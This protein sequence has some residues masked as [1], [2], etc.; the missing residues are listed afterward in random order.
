V[1]RPATSCPACGAEGRPATGFIAFCGRCGHRW[2]PTSEEEQEALETGT[3]TRDYSGYRPDPKFID[4]ATRVTRSEFATRVPPPGRILDVGCGAGDF[5]G[6]AKQF[7]YSAEG[8]DISEA[9]AEICRSRGHDARSGN[10]LTAEFS[11]PFDLI[12][13]WDVV[14]HLRDPA[15][16]LDRARSLLSKRGVVFAKIPGF[17]DLSV[18]MSN[19]WPRAAGILLGA[20]SHVQYFD[21]ESL[22]A[23]LSRTGFSAEWIDGGA[24]RSRM[25]GG[26]LRKRAAR[27]AK[28][29]IGRVSGDANFYVVARPR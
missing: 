22:S 1:L 20:P 26:P 29:L 27:K 24:A 2:L 3:Y 17:G 12:T 5:M 28:Q 7:G 4:T 19:L 10:F 13:M 15:A 9:S 16:F 18:A 14:E 21:L 6:V 11:G 23:L 8:I 25:T